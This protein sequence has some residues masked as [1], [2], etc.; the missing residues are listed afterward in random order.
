MAIIRHIV[1]TDTF[2]AKKKLFLFGSDFPTISKQHSVTQ[3]QLWLPHGRLKRRVLELFPLKHCFVK[4][5]T[6]LNERIHIMKSICVAQ[7]FVV[8]KKNVPK[9]KY[10]R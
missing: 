7:K 2:R 3:M 4:E 5:N 1:C 10:F 8:K 9:L 6:I